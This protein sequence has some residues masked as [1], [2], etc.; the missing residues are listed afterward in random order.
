[1]SRLEQRNLAPLASGNRANE[2]RFAV[3]VS[4]AKPDE[5]WGREAVSPPMRIA[6]LF[7]W[8]AEL[9]GMLS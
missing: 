2:V 4:T 9:G 7:A 1:M 8:L 5:T 3:D 6:A